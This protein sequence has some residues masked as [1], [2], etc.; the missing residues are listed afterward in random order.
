METCRSFNNSNRTVNNN[1]TSLITMEGAQ[2]KMATQFEGIKAIP[3]T[4]FANWPAFFGFA[5]VNYISGMV[6][7]LLPRVDGLPGLV[8]SAAISGMVQ[9]IDHVTWE[10]LRVA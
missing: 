3:G 1:S 5:A 6:L 9:V 2:A 8:E 7:R 4:V 10:K